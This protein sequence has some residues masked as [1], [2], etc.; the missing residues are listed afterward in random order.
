MATYWDHVWCCAAWR[1][2][3]VFESIDAVVGGAQEVEE[4]TKKWS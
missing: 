2:L 3:E 4:E 1:D